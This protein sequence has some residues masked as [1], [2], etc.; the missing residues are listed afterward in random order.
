MSLL[1]PNAS[2]LE[3]GIAAASARVGD[4][5]VP[6]GPL[7][8]PE[9]CPTA[10]LPYLAFALSIDSWDP[11]WP[12]AI[13]R[14][15]VADAITQHRR[16]GTA[17]SIRDIIGYFGG[18]LVMREWW[19]S[20]PPGTPHTFRLQLDV[21]GLDGLPPSAA[22]IDQLVD[23]IRRTKPVR[24]HFTFSQAFQSNLGLVP[25]ARG[26]VA[27][28]RRLTME[29]PVQFGRFE[30]TTGVMP[31]GAI[32]ARSTS[33]WRTNAAGL[34]QNM[35]ANQPRFDY[36]PDTLALRGLLIEPS[37]VNLVYPASDIASG[38]WFTENGAIVTANAAV[39]PDGTTTAS[40]IYLPANSTVGTYRDIARFSPGITGQR[41]ISVWLKGAT[42]G[43][44][45]QLLNTPEGS[46]YLR[47]DP[48][49][50]VLTNQ[51]R[52]YTMTGTQVAPDTYVIIGVDNRSGF[53]TTP[54]QTFHIWGVQAE[55]AASASSFIATTT[56][57]ATRAADAV[58]LNWA[59]RGA[60]DGNI[61]VRY[62]FDDNSTQD[63]VTT[64]TDG[65]ASVPANLNRRWL[66]RAEKL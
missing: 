5:P 21:D 24:S 35:A 49:P 10:L 57:A 63:V 31:P 23:E 51:W 9:T 36:D 45:V 43:E 58:T 46:N 38:E 42:G 3:N 27:L 40:A 56:A 12:E 64:V 66:K 61:T 25:I 34:L 39:A 41:T 16:K 54:D 15:R 1:P 28:Y 50:L 60:A 30:F 65:V 13:K 59:S 53:L 33:A 7:W 29:V 48:D 8:D 52:R 18:R 19:E 32:I 37:A 4:L 62:T 6:F 55:L 17:R 20:V 11:A 44:R 14:A 26:R 47:S 2:R 22:F